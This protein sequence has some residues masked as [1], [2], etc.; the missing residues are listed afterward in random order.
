MANYHVMEGEQNSFQII[1]H[2]PVPDESNRTR[3]S[4]IRAALAEDPSVGRTSRLPWISASEQASL[5]NGALYEHVEVYS[6]HAGHSLVQ[7][8]AALDARFVRLSAVVVNRLRRRY[9]F[10]RFE[11]NVP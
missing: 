1:F 8:R 7:D 2:L 5:T 10:W 3:T 4:N 11:R 9:A 6:T